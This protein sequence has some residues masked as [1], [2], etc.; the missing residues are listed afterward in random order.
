VIDG[1]S[2]FSHHFLNVSVTERIRE[3]PPHTL[4]DHVALKMAPF[5]GYRGHQ[6]L[7]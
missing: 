7:L 2:T 1:E 3:V 4:K 5:K 6:D